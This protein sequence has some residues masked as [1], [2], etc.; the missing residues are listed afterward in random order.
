M[1]KK[2]RQ[3]FKGD[4][5]HIIQ[6]GNNRSYIFNEQ[7]DKAVFL[8]MIKSARQERPFHLLFY[9]LMDNHYHLI[10]EM[11]DVPIDQAM[12]QV[13]LAYSKYFNKKYNCIGTV[14]GQRY[15][16]YRVTD[17][18]YLL[19]LILYIANNPVKAGMVKHLSD[20]R[21]SANLE[22]VSLKS[23]VVSINRL[24]RIL[25]KSDRE[26]K[27]VRDI[28]KQG[29]HVY[30]Q[31]IQQNI[32]PVSQ[33]RTTADFNKE[34]RLEHL[35]TLK[36]DVLGG[37]PRVIE[38]GEKG[39]DV[40]SQRARQEFVRQAIAQGYKIS[41]IA[42]F[43]QISDRAVRMVRCGCGCG[44]RYDSGSDDFGSRETSLPPSS[45]VTAP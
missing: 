31:L 20:Y 14:F 38:N 19:R 32:V 1:G 2:P 23:N 27:D 33:A 9:V 4:I 34:R 11:D 24:F 13:N 42:G 12:H 22:I 21:W 18:G 26:D 30:E 44:T 35:E 28:F 3:F 6:R 8:D 36:A 17:F 41:E 45:S 10:V 25:S 40:H 37:Q 5:Y 15:R 29:A 39:C 7:T 43:L 16:S